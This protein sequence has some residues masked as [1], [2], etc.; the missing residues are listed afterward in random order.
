MTPKFSKL[1][2]AYPRAPDK[3]TL[4]NEIGGGW[5]ALI[6]KPEYDNTCTIRLSIAL[7]RVGVSIPDDLSKLDGGHK[8]ANGRNMIVRV[9]T[10]GQLLNILLGQF[11]WGINKQ[12]GSDIA[13]GLIPARTGVL[14]YSVPPPSD[15]NG[16][17]DLWNRDSC[18][19]DCHNQYARSATSVELW[20]LD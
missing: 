20:Y 2:D 19:I 6:K 3:K 16:H 15:A 11:G 13:G 17:V 7:I 9:P 18:T 8:D 10:A 1:W 12:V 4:F 14:L 5:P